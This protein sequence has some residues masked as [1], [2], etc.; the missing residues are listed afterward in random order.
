MEVVNLMQTNLQPARQH[1]RE[2]HD[3]PEAQ[4]LAQANQFKVQQLSTLYNVAQALM[5]TVK[6]E[7]L[8]YIMMRS[9]TAPTGL[10]FSRAILFMLS[11]DDS[12]LTA[13]MG[14]GPRDRKDARSNVSSFPDASEDGEPGG[15]EKLRKL[16]WPDIERLS[17]PLHGS[18]CLVAKAVLEKK[19]VQTRTGCGQVPS[20][21]TVFFCGN[22]PDIFAVVPLVFKGKAR[23]A[24]YVDNMFREREITGEDIQI[25]TM[26]A[27]EAC[28]AMEN[29]SLYEDLRTRWTTCGRCRAACAEREAGG[30]G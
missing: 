4:A 25:L 29:A 1:D 7:R 3:V 22:H 23:G 17:I 8:L 27:S 13:R 15:D 5:S 30:A 10:N 16:L 19:P 20:G 2:F 9:L 21:P 18:D 14:M 28:L 24:I 11:E 6:T 12:T 26:F